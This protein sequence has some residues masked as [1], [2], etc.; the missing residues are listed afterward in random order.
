MPLIYLL[1][2]GWPVRRSI[3]IGSI[4]VC[5]MLAWSDEMAALQAGNE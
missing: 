2:G 1:L 5:A 3:L 4:N